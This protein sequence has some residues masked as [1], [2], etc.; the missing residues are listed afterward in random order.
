MLVA[1]KLPPAA[2]L[3]LEDSSNGLRAATAA[4]LATVITPTTY[5]VHHNFSNA[6]RVVPDLSQVNLAR[7]R[8]WHAEKQTPAKAQ[9]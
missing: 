7:L 1:L 6:L 5:T 2:C 3:A 9:P 4:G 8:Q